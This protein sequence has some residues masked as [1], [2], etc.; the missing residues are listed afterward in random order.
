[1]FKKIL[2]FIKEEV[3]I[4]QLSKQPWKKS[5]PLRIL[6]IILLAIRGFKEDQVQIRASAL[7]LFTLLSIVPLAAMAF[8]FAQLF[9]FEKTLEKQLMEYFAGQQEVMEWILQFA[10]SFLANIKG[11]VI[12]GIGAIILFWSVISVLS[13]IEKS[14][15]AIWQVQKARVWIRKFTDYISIMLIAIILIPLSSSATVFIT[16]QIE[17]ITREVDLLGY[18]SPIF[19]R[20]MQLLPYIFMWLLLTILYMVMPNTKVNFKSALIAG[21]IAGSI[22]QFT[23]WGYI[24]FQ[25][26]VSRYGAVYGSFAAF[27]LFLI[28]LQ[29][30]WLIILLGAEISFADQNVQSYEF[31]SE[32]HNIS[33]SYKKLIALMVTNVAVKT[34]EKGEKALT[35]PEIS[36]RLEIPIRLVK[37]SINEL[38]AA[39]ILNDTSTQDQKGNAYQPASDIAQLSIAN[40]LNSLDDKGTDKLSLPDN[41]AIINLRNKLETLRKQQIGSEGNVLL[42]DI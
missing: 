9:G 28:W 2:Q 30:S 7:T 18:I 36:Q 34:F 31:E 10:Q 19:I 25:I 21:V 13:N 23:Q 11:G 24:H 8:G 33:N 16:T 5:L 26:G 39:G 6:R 22:F 14:F 1:M 38:I 12:V 4:I 15:N 32:S 17:T 29:I 3:W 20:S 27:P 42:K 41:E 37:R 35:A 40:V